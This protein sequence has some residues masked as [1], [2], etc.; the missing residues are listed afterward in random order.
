MIYIQIEEVIKKKKV[1]W[2]RRVTLVEVAQA[3]GISR[4]TLHRILNQKGRN[5]LL[6][7][8]DKLCAFFQCELHELV[9]YVPDQPL[10]QSAMA[11]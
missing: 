5:T 8:I 2:G 3:T 4:M 1:E 6:E 7:H 10:E 11:A 9:K